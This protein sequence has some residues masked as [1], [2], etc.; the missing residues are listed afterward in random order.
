LVV[1]FAMSLILPDDG[2]PGYGDVRV[3]IKDHVSRSGFNKL[4]RFVRAAR[5]Q[6]RPGRDAYG[7]TPHV[8]PVNSWAVTLP[9]TYKS[10][11]EDGRQVRP[12][13]P[14]EGGALEL[15]RFA[16]AVDVMPKD[17]I[18]DPQGQTIERALPS[19]GFGDVHDVRVGKRIE[20]VVEAP[21]PGTAEAVVRAACVRFLA[22]PV[23]EDFLIH[24]SEPEVV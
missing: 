5:P 13:G 22:N 11:K 20:L 1:V 9:A 12:A 8:G 4:Y 23:I 2:Y 14:E 16:V 6:G 3:A 21:D 7:K 18:S 10:L 24:I 19:L 15:V 17:G